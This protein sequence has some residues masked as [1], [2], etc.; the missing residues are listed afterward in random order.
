MPKQMNPLKLPRPCE[1]QNR[2][3]IWPRKLEKREKKNVLSIFG[4]RGQ[5]R[6]FVKGICERKLVEREK[7]FGQEIQGED[8][9]D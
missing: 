2:E 9:A 4:A 1:L 7:S 3:R 5:Q 8:K 6:C